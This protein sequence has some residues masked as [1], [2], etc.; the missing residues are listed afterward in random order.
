MTTAPGIEPIPQT[1]L[2]QLGRLRAKLTQWILVHGLGRWLL[3]LV[4]I[5]VADM[6]LDRLFKMD[7]AQRAI[8]LVAMLGIGAFYFYRR[9]MKPMGQRPNDDALLY[10]IESQNPDLKES[11][12]SSYQLARSKDLANSGVSKELANETIRRGVEKAKSINFASVLDSSGSMTNWVILLAGLMILGGLGIGVSQTKFL[13]TWFNRNILLS[14]DQWPQSTYLEVVGAV[15]GILVVPRGSDQRQLVRVTEDSRESSVSVELEVDSATGRSFHLMKTTGKLEG[16]EHVFVFHNVS[17]EFRFRAKGGDDLTEWV[18]IRLVEPP[19]IENL[20]IEALPPEYTRIETMPLVGSGPHSVLAGSRLQVRLDSNK[21]LT[22]CNLLRGSDKITLDPT[23][24]SKQA[25]ATTFPQNNGEELSG[26]EYEF[27]LV[28]E[29]GLAS[30]RPAKFSITIKEDSAPK[31]RAE[32]LGISSMVVPKAMLPVS[33][34]AIDDFG[35]KALKFDC[36]WK[37][38]EEGEEDKPGASRKVDL[39]PIDN[40]QAPV[41]ELADVGVLDLIP[42][43]LKPKMRLRF[44]LAAS[45]TKPAPSG[46]AK[47]QEFVL[48]IVTEEELR[49]NLLLREEEQRKAFEAAYNSQQELMT[50]I[51]AI[52]AMRPRNTPLDRFHTERESRLISVYREQKLVGTSLDRIASRFEEFLVEVKNNRLDETDDDLPVAQNLERRFDEKIIQPIREIDRDFISLATRSLDNCRRSVRDNEELL[53]SVDRTVAIQ[54]QILERMKAV[55]D[56][57]SDSENFQKVI[58]NFLELK[59]REERLKSE[60]KDR[61]KPDDIFDESDEDDIFDDN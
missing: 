51:Q 48:Q 33:F 46:R 55:L 47:S 58:N 36:N 43:N 12:I 45:D 52:A 14:D 54:M 25:F 49:A 22:Q 23:G 6:L 20:I 34:K 38:T 39:P 26:G 56:S 37:S 29:S 2:N 59:R 53:N 41:V 9:V 1:V 35:L 40:S 60:I 8:M 4:G 3:I 16:R 28:D 42:L 19:S 61:N 11:L 27:E 13:N 18:Q 31:V 5:L 15:D 30:N 32:L 50:E 21:P 7:F 44:S 17:S 57:M 24:D 10:E